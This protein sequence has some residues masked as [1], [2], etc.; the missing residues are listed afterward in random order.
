MVT[1][2]TAYNPMTTYTTNMQPMNEMVTTTIN[3]SE[4]I[5]MNSNTQQYVVGG[6]TGQQQS[7]NG[8]YMVNERSIS[9]GT[10]QTV[11]SSRPKSSLGS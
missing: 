10:G 7:H 3:V 5:S 6:V 1:T 4:P 11:Q 8:G 9:S 2:T